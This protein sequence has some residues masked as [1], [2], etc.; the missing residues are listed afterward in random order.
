MNA[1][2]SQPEE[3]FSRCM[4]VIDVLDDGEEI[5]CGSKIPFHDQLCSMCR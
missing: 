4:G 2:Q 5:L 1:L 3:R